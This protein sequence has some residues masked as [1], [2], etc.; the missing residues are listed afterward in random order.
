MWHGLEIPVALLQAP[1]RFSHRWPH[2]KTAWKLALCL[3][4][5]STCSGRALLQDCRTAGH[6]T[7][8]LCAASRRVAAGR[9]QATARNRPP[10]CQIMGTRPWLFDGML[11]LR[12]CRDSAVTGTLHGRTTGANLREGRRALEEGIRDTSEG[13][14]AGCQ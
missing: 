2:S 5:P 14:L 3:R 9:L 10:G 13:R 6:R 7:W 11:A 4:V 8:C 1:T 12:V